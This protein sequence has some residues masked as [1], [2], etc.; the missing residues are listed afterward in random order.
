[1]NLKRVVQEATIR[2][3]NRKTVDRDGAYQTNRGVPILKKR[4]ATTVEVLTRPSNNKVRVAQQIN[5]K[6][7]LEVV[8]E[9][10]LKV[11][12]GVVLKVDLEAVLKVDRQVDLQVDPTIQE[13]RVKVR[14]KVRAAR[15]INSKVVVVVPTTRATGSQVDLEV[16]RGV[17][18]QVEVPTTGQKKVI[19]KILSTG[20]LSTTTT[21]IRIQQKEKK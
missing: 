14:A 6:V 11:D 1:V 13:T 15:E 8:L 9:V 19:W 4:T 20:L 18:I 10:V 2:E 17:R 5:S 12:L 7:D 21:K 16:D 3:I